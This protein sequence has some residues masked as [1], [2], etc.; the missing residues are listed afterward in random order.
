MC[1]YS[2]YWNLNWMEILTLLETFDF[3]IL[4]HSSAL[5]E[6]RLFDCQLLRCY[7]WEQCLET[8]HVKD[9]LVLI[10]CRPKVSNS[11]IVMP[12][13][14]P[15]TLCLFSPKCLFQ[16]C[17]L[18]NFLT[19]QTFERILAWRDFPWVR[20]LTFWRMYGVTSF[21]MTP[22]ALESSK[23][24]QKIMLILILMILI[25]DFMIPGASDIIKWYISN[26]T[27]AP[28]RKLK[29]DFPYLASATATFM[30]SS[31]CCP[32]A[33]CSSGMGTANKTPLWSPRDKE[34]AEWPNKTPKQ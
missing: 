31:I 14:H 25:S 8:G 28:E 26:P 22:S 15:R 21:P 33:A 19:S 29:T 23:R 30:A 11:N 5:T 16:S 9:T 32:D 2:Q 12:I 3:L 6:H 7:E 17:L 10:H 20:A 27:L 13:N 18:H 34:L 4:C 24:E 1:L